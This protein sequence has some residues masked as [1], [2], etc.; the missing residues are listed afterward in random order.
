MQ[1]MRAVVLS[2]GG[3][4]GS[5]QIGVWKALRRLHIKYDIVTGTSVG[6]LN[7]A[8]MVQKNYY[9]A[10]LLWRKINMKMLFGSNFP[11]DSNREI[12]KMFRHQFVQNGG[13]DVKKIESLI[14]QYVDTNKFFRSKI[15][16]GLVTVSLSKRKALYLTKDKIKKEKLTD[17]LMAS[18]SCYPAF[19]M[20][21]I[22]EAKYIDGGFVDNMPINMAINLGAD[23][24]IAVD[25]NAPGMIRMPLKRKVPITI[26][27]PNNDLS[28]FLN[29]NK[30]LARRNMLFGYNDTMK[31]FG[32]F[33]GHKYTFKKG[34]IAKCHQKYEK[35]CTKYFSEIF[36]SKKLFN[37]LIN[38]PLMK[39]AKKKKYSL[40]IM[41]ELGVMFELDEARVYSYRKFNKELQ[42]SVR[43]YTK[44]MDSHHKKITKLLQSKTIV[45]D[46]YNKIR[47]G[48]IKAVRQSALL[49]PSE[50]LKALYLYA[51]HEK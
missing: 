38:L 35:I 41:E 10:L 48:N 47:K 40:T 2:G 37:D 8:L 9:K 5:Y 33:E 32:K 29:F 1:E 13:V 36:K 15:Q 31:K 4:K 28:F 42:K 16:Y 24:V 18:A 19:Q 26:I 44:S 46:I 11:L 23:E 25:L 21:Q 34:S 17:Y 20:K 6:A 14:N 7:G 22:D 50:F 39:K 49:T 45:I 51:I 3:A 12:L 43:N 30:N 27:K